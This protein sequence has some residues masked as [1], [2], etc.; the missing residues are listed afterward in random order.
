ML[1]A[2]KPNGSAGFTPERNMISGK[3]EI[4]GGGSVLTDGK[5]RVFVFW[6]A[7]MP[8]SDEAHGRVYMTMSGDKGKR[9]SQE[10]AIDD[11]SRGTCGCC[12]MQTLSSKAKL[13]V[14]YRSAAD[15]GTAR[16]TTLLVSSNGGATFQSRILDSWKLTSCP[17]TFFALSADGSGNPVAAWESKD[18]IHYEFI[19]SG[20][21][22]ALHAVQAPAPEK[23]PTLASQKDGK[24]LLAF[25]C[26]VQW[27]LP[28]AGRWEIVNPAG[29]KPASTG[30]FAPVPAWS[31]GQAI[32]IG[33]NKFA[34]IF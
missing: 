28:S 25:D 7:T 6:H 1:F 16:D 31:F 11:S 30:T 8:G 5:G 2:R 4:D 27:G 3:E 29:L 22:K 17:V 19:E 34:I 9:F 26:G 12:G 13:Y 14:M 21:A 32:A 18:G 33:P 24:T 15:K 10:R 20:D 23:Y